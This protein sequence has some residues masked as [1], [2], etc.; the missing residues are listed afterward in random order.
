MTE[1]WPYPFKLSVVASEIHDDPTIALPFAREL[2][3]THVEL[4]RLWG[5][6]ITDLTDAELE[7]VREQLKA[8]DLKVAMVGPSTFKTVL[9]GHLGL[10]E[11]GGDTHFQAELEVIRRAM[12]LS[13]F[14]AAPLVRTFSFRREGMIGLGNPSPRYPRGGEI[15]AE[16]LEKIRKGFGLICELAEKED[17]YLGLENVRSCWANTGWNTRRI[18]EAA[19]SSRLKVVWDPANAFV[20]GEDAA[21]PKGYVQI[22]PYMAHMHAKDA[23]LLDPKTGLTTWERIGDGAVDY[24]G[25]MA[26]LV[27]DGYSATISIETHYEPPGQTPAEATRLTTEGLRD[28]LAS[29]SEGW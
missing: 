22:K 9:L 6:K 15:P 28:V 19:G 25:Q 7:Q 29:L 16:M 1:T 21:Y 12:E 20:S 27:E 3:M 13:H 4:D 26:A 2:G 11:I 10:E 18:V 5:R 23:R 14:F 17:V 8:L 24:K